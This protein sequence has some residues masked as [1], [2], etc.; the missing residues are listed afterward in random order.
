MLVELLESRQLFA[1]GQVVSSFADQG[2]AI[3]TFPS[4]TA[5]P[6][7]QELSVVSG[8]VIAGG[9]AG[10]AQYT[11]A[12]EFDSS[13]GTSGRA[14]FPGGFGFKALASDP[15]GNLY[16]L[17][18]SAGKTVLLRYTSAGDLDASYASGGQALV[19]SSSTFAPQAVAVQP[20]GKVLIAGIVKDTETNSTRVR[21]YRLNSDSSPDTNWGTNSSAGFQLGTTNLLAPNLEDSIAGVAIL[22]DGKLL[23]GGGSKSY[24]PGG[25]DPTT[26]ITTPFAYGAAMFAVARLNLDGTLD[27]TYGTGG[28]VRSQYANGTKS[29]APTAFAVHPDGTAGLA[30]SD[31]AD[32]RLIVGLFSPAGQ[33]YI[34]KEA[35]PGYEFRNPTDMVAHADGRFFIVGSNPARSAAAQVA[36]VNAQGVFSNIIYTADN[37]PDTIDVAGGDAGQIAVADDGNLLVAGQST[38]P[39]LGYAMEKIEP[40][41]A[42]SPRPDEFTSARANDIYR[43]RLGGLHVAFYDAATTTLKYAYRSPS[44]LW[45]EPITVDAAPNAGQYLSI[46][47]DRNG[48]PGIAYFD[49]SSGDL[50][51]AFK[52]GASWKTETVD[53]RGSVGLYP[54]MLF[55]DL[56]R[57][58]AVYY[59]KSHGDL[60]FAVRDMSTGGWRFEVVQRTGDVGRSSSLAIDPVSNH[61]VVAYVDSTKKQIIWA[62]HRK[63]NKWGYMVAASTKAGADYLSLAYTKNSK[64]PTIAF[65]DANSSDLKLAGFG[66]KTWAVRTLLSKGKVGLYNQLAYDASGAT[67]Y[68]YDKTNDRLILVRDGYQGLTSTAL[69]SSAGKYLSVFSNGSVADMAYFDSKDDLLKVRSAPTS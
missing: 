29:V 48:R 54:S 35:D 44:G 61:F 28:I 46:A 9:N 5:A 31:A 38:E 58:T 53:S 21:V 24:A 42:E 15:S 63:A 18:T 32:G 7:V 60:K 64:Q 49:G 55:D 50:K 13:F 51:F 57:P 69:Q 47:A 22:S 67:I 39:P 25:F 30:T 17:G 14:V 62:R 68:T 65:Y 45:D 8:K 6:L 2:H 56:G 10:L 36:Y 27:T 52:D 41:S 1:F 11:S 23:V 43:D 40:G 59:D 12:G 37:D 19:T 20:D 66:G 26:G 33:L 4:A 34:N 3:A 16:C